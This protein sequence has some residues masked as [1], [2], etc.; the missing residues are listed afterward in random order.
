MTTAHQMQPDAL[1]LDEDALAD[2]VQ[3]S[4]DRRTVWVHA[5]DGSTVGRFSKSFGVDVHRT[6]TEQ[7]KGAGECLSCTHE[8]PAEVDW[9][10]FVA[11]IKEHYGIVVPLDA[12]EPFSSHPDTSP[13][14]GIGRRPRP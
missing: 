2:Q 1:S 12:I 5:R 6:M 10:R 11:L 8:P 3:V 4:A 14:R 13:G 7:M 9:A